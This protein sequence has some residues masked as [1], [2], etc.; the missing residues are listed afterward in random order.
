MP[1]TASSAPPRVGEANITQPDLAAQRADR[2]RD[3]SAAGVEVGVR[4][5]SRRRASPTVGLLVAV[6]DLR[7]LL[8]RGRRTR[9]CRGGRRSAR[10]A[11]MRAVAAAGRRRSSS[12]SRRRPG[13]TAAG[14]TGSRWRCSAVPAS[15]TRGRLAASRRRRRSVAL[16]AAGTPGRSAAR[17]RS[18]GRSA[19]TAL[20]SL[21]GLGVGRHR[22]GAGRS[23]WR[24][25]ST[26]SMATSDQRQ[27]G[28]RG[29]AARPGRRRR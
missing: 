7:E 25:T 4:S 28:R 27:L 22:L 6:E 11:V 15:G 24:P 29:P 13:R 23:A 18:P 1:A 9:P 20:T 17:R 8:D 5:R 3:R 26:G 21:A 2:P 12:T 19:L 14:R 10:P 16:L